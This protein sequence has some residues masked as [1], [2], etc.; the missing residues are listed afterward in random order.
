MQ[1]DIRDGALRRLGRMKPL[2]MALAMAFGIAVTGAAAL[3]QTPP[4]QSRARYEIPAGP[5]GESL[6]RFAQQAGAAIVIDT[7]RVR[8]LRSPGLSGHFG[9]EEGF[10][11]LLQGSGFVIG[12]TAA[13]YVLVASPLADVTAPPAAPAAERRP[14]ASGAA[15]LPLVTV[16]APHESLADLPSVRQRFDA[17]SPQVVVD[18][19]QMEAVGDK[20]LS[21]IA[22]RLPGAFAGG[23]PGE[24][25]SINLR[26]VSSEFARF[27]FAGV[28]LP[29]STA[30]RNIDLQR[31]SGFIMEDVTYLRSPSAEYE[32]DGLSGRLSFRTRA[33]P[34]KPE[35]E[36]DLSAGGLDKL[37][38]SN[39]SAKVG[40]AGRLN[41]D[42]GLIA[43][44]GYDRFDSIKI[45]DR[46]ERTFSGGGGPALNQGS[47]IDEREPKTNNNLNLFMDLVHYHR[48]GEI[49][50]K[51]IL[52]DTLVENTGRRRDTINRV[53]GT[54]RQRTLASGEEDSRTTGLSVSGKHLFDSGVEIDGEASTSRST[55]TT[56][57]GDITLGATLAFASASAS[58]AR[59]EDELRQ[60]AVN[61]AMPLPGAL[62]QR[63]KVGAMARDSKLRSNAD[64][65]TVSQTGVRSQSAADI[66][67][68]REGDFNISEDYSALYVQDE[69]RA[70][71]WTFLPGMRYERAQVQTTGVNAT[72]ARQVSSD[73]LPSLPVS[74]RLSDQVVLRGS[75]AKHINR[76]KLDE[77]A[78]GVSTRGNRTFT[79]NPDLRP[80]RSRSIDVGADYSQGNLFAGVNLFH[81]RITDLNET[82]E[83][84]SNNFVYRNAG[85]GVIRGLEFDQRFQ[86]G[87]VG[88]VWLKGLSVTSNQAFLDSRVDDATTGPRP[89]SE[90]PKFIANLIFDYKPAPTGLGASLAISRIGKRG[91][92]SNEG[93]GS[94]RDKTV[95]AE[96]FVDVRM[97]WRFSPQLALYASAENI[98]DQ[99][100]DE[101]EY[102]NGNIDR[103]AVIGTGRSFFVGLKWRL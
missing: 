24:K 55:R 60:L 34:D 54:F 42:F 36:A 58:E 59:A 32:A 61:L 46:S 56:R 38:G 9:I 53:P 65:F 84:T 51:P 67:R 83:P 43:A 85:N 57:N 30:S 68:S 3:A 37:D 4:G 16:T 20:R 63:L 80:A 23:P 90:Q 71:R 88:P 18:R 95:K 82:L 92:I 26:G 40:F 39:R 17:V 69:I 10:N 11:R 102:L 66:A 45:K 64:Q 22:G 1:I 81:R 93:S 2:A 6:N 7:A 29:S 50:V 91:I 14:V 62:Q 49:H 70:G 76:P 19:A 87:G 47:L 75:L 97:E 72:G 89:F 52:L 96:T 33:V 31:I 103:I 94:I 15:D 48:G 41:E 74:Y 44:L 13:G 99:K 12:K 73:W 28:N 98:T 77:M 21:D 27:S 79:G 25:K 5:L 100:R 8:G 78:P 35:F 86:L 101:F